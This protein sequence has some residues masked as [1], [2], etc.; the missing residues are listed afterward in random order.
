[1]HPICLWR[2]P[3]FRPIGP[4]VGGGGGRGLLQTDPARHS[5]ISTWPGPTLPDFDL[6]RPNTPGFRP[7]PAQHS[8]ISTWPDPALPDFDW[9]GPTWGVGEGEV[10]YRQ[11]RPGTPGFRPTGPGVGGGGRRG[12]LQTNPAQFFAR[13]FTGL[14]LP[15]PPKTSVTNTKTYWINIY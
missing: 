13:Y 8:Q 12:L 15:P 3:A 1:M 2:G 10:C 5:R 7:D 14:S 6:T 9:P 11:T 4:D